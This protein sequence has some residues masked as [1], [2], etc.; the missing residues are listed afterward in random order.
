MAHE[1]RQYLRT[2]IRMAVQFTF[3]QGHGLQ[4]ETWDI[5]DGGIGI[6][7]PE[8]SDTV[9]ALGMKVRAKVI[10]LPIEG[11]ELQ[12]TVTNITRQRIGLRLN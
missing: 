4:V 6:H 11:P 10:G 9:W 3:A 12:L 5:S 2:P 1:Q 8:T 7:L